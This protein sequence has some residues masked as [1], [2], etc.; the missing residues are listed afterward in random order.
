MPE[1]CGE[2]LRLS[3][4]TIYQHCHKYKEVTA[5]IYAH[6][7]PLMPING[8]WL[9]LP[10]LRNDILHIRI[11][12]YMEYQAKIWKMGVKITN[13]EEVYIATLFRSNKKQRERDRKTGG[14]IK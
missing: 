12:T 1:D 8:L 6:I 11:C 4:G 5:A 9:R 14:I 13:M 7:C 2:K 10:Q 3:V